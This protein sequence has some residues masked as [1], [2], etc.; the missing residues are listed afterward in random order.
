MIFWS[1]PVSLVVRLAPPDEKS[2]ALGLLATGTSLAKV[3]AIP[4]GRM[5]GESLGW[6]IAFQVIAVA[7]VVVL[8]MLRFILPNLERE[9]AGSLC[10]LP[11]RSK[12]RR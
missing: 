7:A 9:Q 12:T 5:I 1:I 3:A 10:S 8:L 11:F 4:I 2:R 6:R